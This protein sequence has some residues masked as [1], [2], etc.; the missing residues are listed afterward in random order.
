MSVSEKPLHID[1]PVRL[2]DKSSFSSIRTRL[3]TVVGPLIFRQRG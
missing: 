1:I 2:E 3:G